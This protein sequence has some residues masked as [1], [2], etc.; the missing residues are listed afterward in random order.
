V[1]EERLGPVEIVREAL[2][3]GLRTREG[4]DLDDTAARAGVDPCAGRERAIAGRTERGD[5]IRNGAH[6]RVPR[7]RWLTLDAI[8]RDLF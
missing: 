8:V 1:E 7:D 2:M 3:L 6:L 4:V 5:L